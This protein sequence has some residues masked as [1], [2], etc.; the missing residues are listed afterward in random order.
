MMH[1][2]KRK[3][4]L[5]NRYRIETEMIQGSRRAVLRTCIIPQRGVFAHE[6]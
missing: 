3:K 1:I 2:N 6:G 4:S 5:R